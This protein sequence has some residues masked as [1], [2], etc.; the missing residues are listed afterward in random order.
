M[1]VIDFN[2]CVNNEF[3]YDAPEIIANAPVYVEVN[4]ELKPVKSADD[5]DYICLVINI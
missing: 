5:N 2:R 3:C 1:N 4:G